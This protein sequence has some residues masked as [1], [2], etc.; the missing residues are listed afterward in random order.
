MLDWLYALYYFKYDLDQIDIGIILLGI[1]TFVGIAFQKSSIPISLLLVLIG[2]V[3]SFIHSVPHVYLIPDL[4]LE[5]FLPLLIYQVSG[6]TSLRDVFK[7]IQPILLLSIGHVVF[8]TAL[9]AV[10]VHYLF[11]DIS[12]PLACVL[13]AVVSPPDDVAIV[14]IAEK[15]HLPKRIITIL[16]GEGMFNDATSL[17]LFRFSLAAVVTHQFVIFNVVTHFV[18]V[19]ASEI[20]YGMA[21]TYLIGELRIKIN[22]PILQILISILTPFLAYIPAEKLG[23]SGVIATVVC[24]LLMG[25]F[26]KERFTPEVRLTIRT[27]WTTLGY[28]TQSFLFLLVGLE[29]P[30]ILERFSA[31]AST[32][33]FLYSLLI[34]LVV[35]AGRFIWVWCST[36]ITNFQLLKNK[37]NTSPRWQELF[38]ISWSG[39]R[40]GISL[41]AAL[42][43]PSLPLISDDID[44]RDLVIL[45]VFAVIVATLL[46]QGLTLPWLLQVLGITRYGKRE[47]LDQQMGEVL[48]QLELNK[49]VLHW[50]NEFKELSKDNKK[51][52][53]EIKFRIHLYR[54]Y[55]T[56]LEEDLKSRQTSHIEPRK[57]APNNTILL[58][59]ILEVERTE[60]MRLWHE[61]KINHEV[62]TKLLRKLDL[63]A[64]N[65]S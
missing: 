59:K 38:I 60:L 3:L 39:M 46:I 44:P 57:I 30:Y 54:E 20:L 26:Y 8:I 28:I 34:V 35:I 18:G 19:V 1:I 64:R 15:V 14:S 16:K 2:M 6:E 36:Y 12:W 5:L 41:A 37:K 49:A 47:Q 31:E 33:I 9:V 23:G 61:K 45:F 51:L 4:V 27:V 43:V 21:L 25:H 52:G 29:L 62:K 40:G 48:A 58:L 50:L 65:L 11:P 32:T 55:K 7:H 53:E 17:I 42:A 56:Q 22:D 13:G 24:G 63:R 10:S